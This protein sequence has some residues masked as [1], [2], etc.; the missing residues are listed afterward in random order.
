MEE[1]YLQGGIL[2]A[3]EKCKKKFYDAAVGGR[4]RVGRKEKVEGEAAVLPGLR[5]LPGSRPARCGR[6]WSAGSDRK[7]WV[8]FGVGGWSFFML[9]VGGWVCLIAMINK[10]VEKCII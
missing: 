9:C 7:W 6:T 5:G 1:G 4:R 8:L 10:R 3:L 2:G